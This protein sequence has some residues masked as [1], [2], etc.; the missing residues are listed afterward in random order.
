[1]VTVWE[2]ATGREVCEPIREQ[3]LS[4]FVAFDPAGKYL[5][6]EG[7]TYTVQVRDAQSGALVGVVG[8]H[9][10]QIW[11]AAFS[12]DGRRL[13]TA[14]SDGT[15]RVWAWDPAH[16][17]S[18]QEPKPMLHARVG[19]Y[20]NRVAFSRDSLR[21]VTAG[22]RQTVKIWDAQTGAQLQIL[23]GH[24]RD[25]FAVAFS[26]DG[27]WLATAG[28]DTTV[29]IWDATSWQLQRTLRGHTSLIGT[30]AFSPDNQRLASGS[31][32]HTL[33]IWD[34]RQLDAWLQ[35]APTLFS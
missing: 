16:F 23:H 24:T 4:F 10:R 34:M 7:P 11:G 14:S 13:A 28:G 27:R 15:I 2:S 26:R 3:G 17:A 19:G 18:E 22:E 25:V 6:R 29:R 21:L 32:D 31:R 8:R 33:K 5:I 9:D 20:G 12:P 1:V 30:L 35:H